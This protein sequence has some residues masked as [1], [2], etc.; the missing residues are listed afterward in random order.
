M[1]CSGFKQWKARNAQFFGNILSS[2]GHPLSPL[3]KQNR[4]FPRTA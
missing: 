4:A 3:S 2:F 1:G